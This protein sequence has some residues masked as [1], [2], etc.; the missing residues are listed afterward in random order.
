MTK[1]KDPEDLRF[2]CVS[3]GDCKAPAGYGIS[4][5]GTCSGDKGTQGTCYSCGEPVC[6]G[7]N[8][9]QRM[10]WHNYGRKRICRNCHDPEEVKRELAD[11]KT[12]T[13]VTLEFTEAGLQELWR[14]VQGRSPHLAALFK[15]YRVRKFGLWEIGRDG[16][17][18]KGQVKTA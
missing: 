2:C 10:K 9:S 15:R 1:P 11:S 8:C 5:V 4:G 12:S 7:E 17:L 3:N 13:N 6:A 18:V 14:Q 16:Y